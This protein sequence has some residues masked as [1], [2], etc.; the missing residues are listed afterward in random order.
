MYQLEEHIHFRMEAAV[1]I[2]T[3]LAVKDA[4]SP[5]VRKELLVLIS[6]LVKEWRGYFVVC[7]C[8]YWEEDQKR[9][10]G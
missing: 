3:T 6:S 2:G 1:V 9:N 4:A 7:A 10:Y 5:M 8:I